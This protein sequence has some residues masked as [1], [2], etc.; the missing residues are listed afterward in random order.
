MTLTSLATETA[1]KPCDLRGQYPDVVSTDLFHSIG[2]AIGTML[3]PS[4]RVVVAGD[5]RLSTLELK[6][7]LTDGLLH[8]SP[9]GCAEE[10]V[11]RN[12]DGAVN[13]SNCNAWQGQ[14]IRQPQML[15]VKNCQSYN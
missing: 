8:T 14:P 13:E 6:S 9:F 7:A 15:G 1:W 2:G 3:A 12:R 4:A 5:F 10:E 11:K